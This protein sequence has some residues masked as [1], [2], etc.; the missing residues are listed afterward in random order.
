MQILITICARGGSKGI[1]GKNIKN[2]AGKPL[3]AY[4]INLAKK[5]LF[6]CNGDIAI[7][8]DSN[9]ILEVSKKYGVYTDYIRPDYLATDTAGKI[10]AIKDILLFTEKTKNKKYDLILDLDVSS[11]LRNLEDINSAIEI[12]KSDSEALNIFSVSK[13]RKNP[14]FNMVEIKND[15]YVRVV[16]NN[17]LILSRQSAPEVFEMNA[18]FYVYKRRFF[19][20]NL[21]TAITYH[22][23]AFKMNHICFDLDE[24]IDF[25]FME[26][27]IQ[28]NKLDFQL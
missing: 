17:K 12:L 7:S 28:N 9:E 18:S 27:L 22:S 23:L 15:G 21:S 26:Y 20:E 19:S 1:P 16:K 14:Y 11:P 4:S 25:E 3:I 6:S 5:F 13:A 2:L 24:P 10:D 8:T